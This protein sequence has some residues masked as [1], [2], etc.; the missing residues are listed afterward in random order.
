MPSIFLNGL[1]Y[2]Q[3]TSCVCVVTEI[4]PPPASEFFTE[5][6]RSGVIFPFNSDFLWI[7]EC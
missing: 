7:Q 2:P 3:L 4:T 1:K 6:K 5:T